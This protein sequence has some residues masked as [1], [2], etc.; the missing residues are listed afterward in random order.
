MPFFRTR[1]EKGALSFQITAS[2]YLLKSCEMNENFWHIK[3]KF[4]K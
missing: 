3:H 2:M 1:D 4:K